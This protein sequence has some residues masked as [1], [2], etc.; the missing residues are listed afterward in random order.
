LQRIFFQ[1]PECILFKPDRI[2]LVIAAM[3][4][5]LPLSAVPDKTIRYSG[6]S[7]EARF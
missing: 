4:A 5:C 3:A 1:L 2:A 6:A 7:V